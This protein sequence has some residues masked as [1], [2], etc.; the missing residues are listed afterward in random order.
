MFEKLKPDPEREALLH[1]L[2]LKFPEIKFLDS[3]DMERVADYLI[4][5]RNTDD[6]IHSA[7]DW[8]DI[9]PS[10]FVVEIPHVSREEQKEYIRL[11]KLGFTSEEIDEAMRHFGDGTAQGE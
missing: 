3:K 2:K 4:E 11:A 9:F 7:E 5:W 8:K 6:T 1:D 10:G